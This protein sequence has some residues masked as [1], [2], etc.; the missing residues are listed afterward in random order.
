MM[1][2]AQEHKVANGGIKKFTALNLH[3]IYLLKFMGA[4]LVS[5]FSQLFNSSR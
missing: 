2:F 4:Q 3:G 1:A 5:E